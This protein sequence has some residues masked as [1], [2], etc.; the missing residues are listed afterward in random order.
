M[1]KDRE[2]YSRE[3]DAAVREVENG[4]AH[5]GEQIFR[6]MR[7]WGKA[8]EFPSPRPDISKPQ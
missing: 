6:W 2:T 7:S 3:L 8:N 5:T 4:P 1:T